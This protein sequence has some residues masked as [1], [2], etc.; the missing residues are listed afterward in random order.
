MQVYSHYSNAYSADSQYPSLLKEVPN[1]PKKIYSKGS[2][3]EMPLVAVVGTRRPT[4]YGRR[5][6]EQLVSDLVNAGIGIVSGLALGVD[7]VAHRTAVE[8][9][10]YTI[11]V[12]GCGIDRVYP[13]SNR[14]LA[15]N[16]LDSGGALISELPTD[17]EPRKHY[18]PA[19][20]RIIAGMSMGVVVTEAD[21]K[22]GTLHT[23][24]FALEYGREVMAVPGDIYRD[25]SAGPHNLIRQ[26]AQLITEATHILNALNIEAKITS[27]SLQP[28]LNNTESV[29][30]DLMKKGITSSNEL[31]SLSGL[32]ASVYAR[33]IT[34][35]EISGK[36]KNLG[37]GNWGLTTRT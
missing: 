8:A 32:E 33:T 21:W 29:L 10:G 27:K 25:S 35:L 14:E 34:M 9:G 31:I 24:N 26:G 11:A 37:G 28:K 36:A 6:T 19:R 15:K 20:N 12:L 1:C 22:S 7:S 2:L 30:I 16:I 17:T 18:F 4:A 13:S 3:R 23:A 5:V